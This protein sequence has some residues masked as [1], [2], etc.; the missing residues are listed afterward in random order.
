MIL[1]GKPLMEQMA[2]EL[3]NRI[4]A[5]QEKNV[6]P[7][8]AVVQVGHDPAA[9]GYLASILRRGESVGVTV[10][11]ISTPVDYAAAK[12]TLEQLAAD[13]NIHGILLFLPLPKELRDKQEDL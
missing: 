2:E 1:Y 6:Q 7:T 8:L 4:A 10:K 11:S 13:K 9:E 12:E 5:L 3:K